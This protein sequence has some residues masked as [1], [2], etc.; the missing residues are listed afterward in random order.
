MDSVASVC[1]GEFCGFFQQ[2][3]FLEHHWATISVGINVQM[4]I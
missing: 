4:L 1:I 2:P 3:R